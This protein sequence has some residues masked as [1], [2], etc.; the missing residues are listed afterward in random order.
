MSGLAAAERA[1]YEDNGFVIKP[2]L[3]SHTE[4]DR[5][6]DHMLDLHEGR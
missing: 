3:L 2:G 4:C 5:F 1:G 6:V